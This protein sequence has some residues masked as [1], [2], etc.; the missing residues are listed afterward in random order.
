MA[1]TTKQNNEETQDQG[2]LEQQE[3][4][5]KREEN[6]DNVQDA[7]RER[8]LEEQ[9][10][11]QE[12]GPANVDEAPGTATPPVSLGHLSASRAVFDTSGTAG[13]ADHDIRRASAA[14]D[15]LAEARDEVPPHLEKYLESDEGYKKIVD[16]ETERREDA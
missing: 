10:A 13:A 5:A 4:A 16:R 2:A 14:F 12:D 7:D 6:A 15:E 1:R 11:A 8:L 9:H 3:E